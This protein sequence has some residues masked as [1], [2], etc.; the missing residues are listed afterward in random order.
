MPYPHVWKKLKRGPQVIAL[1]DAAAIV[2][3]T[4]MQHGNTVVDAGSGS[5]FLAVYMGNVVGPDGKV[6]S[7][8]RRADFAKLA[9]SNVEIAG[10]QNVV[11]IKEKDV[12]KGIDET[13]VDVVTLDLADAEN[14]LSHAKKAVKENGFIVGYF[15]TIEQAQ[16]FVMEAEKLKLKFLEA[17]EVQEREWKIR[18]YGS[19]PEH[20]GMQFTALLVILKNMRENVFE[21]ERN[22]LQFTKKGRREQRIKKSLKRIQESR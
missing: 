8:E 10:L 5:G 9:K 14:A 1:K 3:H 17:V 11:Q 21:R 13:E 19:R 6:V 20:F 16:R 4:S 2:A 15:P 12:F 18:E 22:A 7:Y